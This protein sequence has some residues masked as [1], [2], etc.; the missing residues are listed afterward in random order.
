MSCN[1]KRPS[2]PFS[3]PLDLALVSSYIGKAP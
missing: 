3:L 2:G 1:E